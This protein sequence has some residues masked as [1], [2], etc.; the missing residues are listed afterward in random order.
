MQ[1]HLE[2]VLRVVHGAHEFADRRVLFR[3]EM[4]LH[5]A[6]EDGLAHRVGE[7]VEVI[8]DADELVGRDLRDVLA[9]HL[10]GALDEQRDLVHL[11]HLFKLLLRGERA[12]FLEPLD[13]FLLE[14][15]RRRQVREVVLVRQE[16]RHVAA[17]AVVAESAAATAAAVAGASAARTFR[18]GL[19]F[20]LGFLD[21]RD[22]GFRLAVSGVDGEDHGGRRGYD[23]GAGGQ[24]I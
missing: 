2:F 13:D 21:G 17:P 3:R 19:F 1:D 7:T 22:L 4:L 18:P 9:E 5:D 6:A 15:L 14:F 16:M 23:A 8:L 12:V 24:G 11:A 10:D 20:F